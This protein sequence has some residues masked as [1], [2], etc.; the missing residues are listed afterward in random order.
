MSVKYFAL[1]ILKLTWENTPLT[2]LQPFGG[3][4]L[5]KR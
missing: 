4:G 5:N 1:N 2:T 3:G